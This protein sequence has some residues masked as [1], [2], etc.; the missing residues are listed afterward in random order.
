[1]KSIFAITTTAL[2]L[3]SVTQVTPANGMPGLFGTKPAP[4]PGVTGKFMGIKLNGETDPFTMHDLKLIGKESNIKGVHYI[5]GMQREDPIRLACGSTSNT[6]N[7]AL[8]VYEDLLKSKLSYETHENFEFMLPKGQFILPGH[9]KC[10]ILPYKECESKYDPAFQDFGDRVGS[11]LE[12]LNRI[13][14]NIAKAL[15]I[16][17]KEGWYA[18][19]DIGNI[20]FTGE[21]DDYKMFFTRFDNTFPVEKLAELQRND[22][23]QQIN[24]FIIQQTLYKVSY[25]LRNAFIYAFKTNK[26]IKWRYEWYIIKAN[27][28]SWRLIALQYN[29]DQLKPFN[30]LLLPSDEE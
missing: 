17:K 4:V 28:P 30:D 24:R 20:C 3:V 6:E 2:M 9:V 12:Y 29:T 22:K 8:Q 7:Y 27:E 25:A 23:I 19:G 10:Y 13:W 26:N 11:Q 14:K 1:M 21:K 18:N 15:D 5:D 16:I